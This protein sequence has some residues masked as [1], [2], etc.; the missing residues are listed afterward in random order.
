MYYQ[1]MHHKF[2]SNR[3]SIKQSKIFIE[4]NYN[5]IYNFI[6]YSKWNILEWNFSVTEIITI[7]WNNWLMCRCV[8]HII[9]DE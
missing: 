7:I 5:W 1:L 9:N 8:D 4:Q 3:N 6:S 2:L